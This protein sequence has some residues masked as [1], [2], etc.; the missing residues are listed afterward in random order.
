VETARKETEIYQLKNVALQ[1][2]I[3]ERRQV[4]EALRVT[5]QQLQDA[6]VKASSSSQI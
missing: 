2:E 5:N 3:H 6:I 4:E 1:Q